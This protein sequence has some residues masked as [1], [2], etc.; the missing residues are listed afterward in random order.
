MN[1]RRVCHCSYCGDIAYV[2][3]IPRSQGF[4]AQSGAGI[5]PG[6]HG[7][8]AVSVTKSQSLGQLCASTTST[9]AMT[10]VG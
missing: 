1:E 10:G 8:R 6:P 2:T 4:K 9:L 5:G 3:T 7:S